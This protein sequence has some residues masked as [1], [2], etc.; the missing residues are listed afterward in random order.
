MIEKLE[1]LNPLSILG[2]G[3]T[4]SYQEDHLVKTI[5]D[6]K[7]GENLQIRMQNGIIHTKVLDK[8]GLES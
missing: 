3:Y 5:D 4:L 1:M 8:K 2:R 7:I 6:V